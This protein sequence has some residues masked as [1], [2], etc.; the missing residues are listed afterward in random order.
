MISPYS[1]DVFNPL[2]YTCLLTLTEMFARFIAGEIMLHISLFR[3]LVSACWCCCKCVFDSCARVYTSHS[4][5]LSIYK[6]RPYK[7]ISASDIVNLLGR[8]C[9]HA[10]SLSLFSLTRLHIEI[11][12]NLCVY[13]KMNEE[14][15]KKWFLVEYVMKG[16]RQYW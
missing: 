1:D 10:F 11:R 3:R 2:I 5:S 8:F 12:F 7:V 4:L 13:F 16:G 6:Y 15:F 9:L 14:T